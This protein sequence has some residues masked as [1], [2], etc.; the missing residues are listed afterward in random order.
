[1]A[2]ENVILIHGIWMNGLE[3][4]LLQRRLGRAGYRVYRFRYPSV[5]GSW[6]ANVA[7]LDSFIRTIPVG[8][9]HLVAHSLGGLLVRDFLAQGTHLSVG[10]VV[11][12]GTPHRG[13]GLASW[14]AGWGVGRRVL[15]G[16]RESLCHVRAGWD[17]QIDLGVVAGDFSFGVGLLMPG[18][19][20]PNDG[21][22]ALAET[23]LEGAADH[24]VLHTS[25][26][27]LLFSARAAAQT[28]AFLREG[29]FT[30][31]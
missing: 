22:V 12:L 4:A 9:T 3:M 26:F 16:A 24:C 1:M 27:G 10:R 20:R 15:G 25:H 11:T 21:T 31:D 6:A 30:R 28:V 14:L 23:A 2:G 29:R 13:S 8:R 7:A 19:E 18:L 5:F 17:G